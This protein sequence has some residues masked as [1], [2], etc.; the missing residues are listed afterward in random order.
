LGPTQLAPDCRRHTVLGLCSGRQGR[1]K[2]PA[3]NCPHKTH[4]PLYNTRAHTHT[5][6]HAHTRARARAHTHT[7]THQTDRQTDAYTHTQADTDTSHSTKT[8]NL[9]SMCRTKTGTHTCEDKA[10]GVARG[11]IAAEC[12]HPRNVFSRASKVEK[13]VFGTA[14]NAAPP[15]SPTVTGTVRS[16]WNPACLTVFTVMRCDAISQ[17]NDFI[18]T[19]HMHA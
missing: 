9:H 19:H 12:G 10:E 16:F 15:S 7:H 5:H 17:A 13:W 8:P 11:R 1:R 4:N 2:S 3:Y 6:A 14:A 18:S